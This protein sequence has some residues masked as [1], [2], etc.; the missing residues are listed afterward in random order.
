MMIWFEMEIHL[1][2]KTEQKLSVSSSSSPSS[3]STSSSSCSSSSFHKNAYTSSGLRFIDFLR[4]NER[5]WKLAEKRFDQLSWTSAGSEPAVKWSNFPFCIGQMLSN[6]I[7]SVF[8]PLIV[9]WHLELKSHL[10]TKLCFKVKVLF[11]NFFSFLFF[12]IEYLFS[13]FFIMLCVFL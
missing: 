6:I 11:I 13:Q 7:L 12:K 1:E 2:R 5:E 3:L 10:V 9:V 8:F 4:D